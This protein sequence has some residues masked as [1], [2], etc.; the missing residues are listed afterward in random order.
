VLAL[1][2][3][4]LKQPNPDVKGVDELPH[5]AA[6]G[7]TSLPVDK[8]VPKALYRTIGYRV[9]GE[10]A[11]RVDILER[12]AD[13]IRPALAWRPNSPG[14]KPPGAVDGSGFTVTGA[15]TSLVGS[16][17]ED[18]ASVLRSL[19][20]RMDRRPKPPEP[21][22]EPPSTASAEADAAGAPAVP[23]DAE[24]VVAS[25]AD[26]VTPAEGATADSSVTSG[27][28]VTEAG[29]DDFGVATNAAAATAADLPDRPTPEGEP[30][31]DA[32]SETHTAASG[33]PAAGEAEAPGALPA[34]AES[35]AAAPTEAGNEPP[36]AAAP[37]EPVL[38]EVWRP[39]R[40]EERRP[41][42]SRAAVPHGNKPRG[43]GPRRESRPVESPAPA[44]AVATANSSSV[45]AQTAAPPPPA[46]QKAVSAPDRGDRRRADERRGPRREGRRDRDE[47]RGRSPRPPGKGRERADFQQ[48]APKER[49]NAEPDPNS[50]FAKLLALKEQLEAN[51]KERR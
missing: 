2:L 11:V 9:C 43:A 51:A 45:S 12:L 1:Q 30:A 16:S 6:S 48:Y 37:S 13:I 47:E 39:G 3:W 32:A 29:T 8:E 42:R 22:P 21:A 49:R 35:D 5:L 15:M 28:S 20:Y 46:E 44:A 41:P 24:A 34:T 7:R 23:P 40:F 14:A 36:A 33:V 10:R 26:N 19:G 17:G 18:F 27:W 31:V 25:G 50:P 4:A 38:I